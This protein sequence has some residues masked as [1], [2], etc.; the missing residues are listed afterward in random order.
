MVVLLL[1]PFISAWELENGV[2]RP[3]ESFSCR[4]FFNLHPYKEILG[5]RVTCWFRDYRDFFLKACSYSVQL[6]PC[7][8]KARLVCV[9]TEGVKALRW[10]FKHRLWS[11]LSTWQWESVSAPS[12]KRLLSLLKG[13]SLCLC[14]EAA[15]MM[16]LRTVRE[17]CWRLAEDTKTFI[18]YLDAIKHECYAKHSQ[19]FDIPQTAL[20][21]LIFTV[22]YKE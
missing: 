1:L 8:W 3:A 15:H 13:G 6:S 14:C 2:S 7:G 20:A 21:F 17:A 22:H 9:L 18:A 5:M 10:D 11:T 19:S 12:P 16:S 4:L